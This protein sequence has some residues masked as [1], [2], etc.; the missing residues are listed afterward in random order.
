MK[1]RA[2]RD[3]KRVVINGDVLLMMVTYITMATKFSE[4]PV[5]TYNVYNATKCDYIGSLLSRSMLQEHWLSEEQLSILGRINDIFSVAGTSG[6]DDSVWWLCYILWRS[7][8]SIAVSA[9]VTNSRTI[10]AIRLTIEQITFLFI[11]V[12]CAL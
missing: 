5:T 6:F 11:C 3:G 7:D 9:L 1:Y 2:E 12:Y 8:L 4:F 10:C